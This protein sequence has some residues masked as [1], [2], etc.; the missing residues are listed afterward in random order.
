MT[1]V[2]AKHEIHRGDPKKPGGIEVIQPNTPFESS[3]TELEGF[4]AQGAVYANEAQARAAIKKQEGVTSAQGVSAEAQTLNPEIEANAAA[5]KRAAASKI[6]NDR[7]NAEK[8]QAEQEAVQVKA[9]EKA[10]AD[11][12]KAAG[13]TTTTGGRNL[14]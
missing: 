5:A 7:I 14:V 3:G 10:D 8:A 1:K 11:A 2:I 13:N 6:E 4:R 9:S 12:A